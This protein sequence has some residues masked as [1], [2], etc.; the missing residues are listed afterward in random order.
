MT[1]RFARLLKERIGLDV[2]SVGE[3]V[4]ARAVRQRCDKVTAG[5]MHA[6][7]EH[8]QASDVE[9]QALVDAVIV[10]ETWFFRYPESFAAL[11]RKAV[12]RLQELAGARPLRMLSVPCSS[13]EEP[14]SMVMALFDAGIPEDAFQVDAVDV[15]P[16]L[17]ERA[18][19]GRYRRNSFR[20]DQLA[21][22]Q[23]HFSAGEQEW[24]ISDAVRGKVRFSCGNLLAPGMLAGEAAYDF[25][26]CRNLLIYFDRTTQEQA[27]Q[28]IKRLTRD[29]GV[30]F[31]GPAEAC[32][33]I[34]DGMRPL[35][36]EQS[37]AFRHKG[38]DE[39]K[40]W[41]APARISVPPIRP[42]P[43][44]APAER[45]SAPPVVAP[46]PKPQV[47]DPTQQSLAQIAELSNRGQFA[48]ARRS[49]MAYLAAHGPSA[50]VYY[51]LGLIC[52]AQGQGDEAH[53]FYRKA[54]YLQPNHQEALL[55]LAALLA[56]RGDVEA[57][58][59]LEERAARG[60]IGDV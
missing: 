38:A 4:V 5:D 34:N 6:Y 46:V 24:R 55:H 42:A 52:D 20:G 48:E 2:A 17:L 23:R 50:A 7:W 12:S 25:V 9:R 15:S 33:L 22:R 56:S 21:F 41:P 26:F 27:V 44:K 40:T 3:T 39:G 59:R 36:M 60:V 16:A 10:P 14:Y 37:F 58:R 19:Q 31:I 47:V 13:G 28:V 32:L 1:E 49:C 11:A 8:L 30:L 53:T 43:A 51:W 45:K 18:E 35:G 57:A 29:D 54:L